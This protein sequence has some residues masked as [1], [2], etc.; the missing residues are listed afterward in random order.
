MLV[1]GTGRDASCAIG[2]PI[3]IAAFMS[4]RHLSNTDG[5]SPMPTNPIIKTFVAKRFIS[6]FAVF[7]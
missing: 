3:C 6:C 1:G 5:I 7:Q 2:E 4:G